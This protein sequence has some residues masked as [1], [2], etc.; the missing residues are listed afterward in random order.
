MSCRPITHILNGSLVT[1]NPGPVKV[2]GLCGFSGS[3]SVRWLFVNPSISLEA[4]LFAIAPGD[5]FAIECYGMEVDN[6]II[7]LSEDAAA[8]E[9]SADTV[10]LTAFVG[11]Y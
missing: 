7:G 1:F 5:N 10:Y 6:L 4:G 3:S 8:F 9:Q 2:F 11:G